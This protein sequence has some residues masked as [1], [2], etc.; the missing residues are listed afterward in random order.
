M[1]AVGIPTS[2][3]GHLFAPAGPRDHPIL[4]GVI[5]AVVAIVAALSEMRAEVQRIRSAR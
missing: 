3:G 2:P 1:R 4:R 5:A